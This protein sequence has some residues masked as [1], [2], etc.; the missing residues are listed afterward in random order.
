MERGWRKDRK[1]QFCSEPKDALTLQKVVI[2]LILRL[3]FF[4]LETICLQNLRMPAF[5][6]PETSSRCLA[7][8]LPAILATSLLA[9]DGSS[10]ANR[11][12]AKRQAALQEGQMLLEKGDEA[13]KAGK[14]EEA[15]AAYAGA[16]DSFPQA[17][18]TAELREAATQRYAQA[19]VEVSKLQA[20][21]GDVA[22]ARKTM[23]NILDDTVAPD[24]QLANTQLGYLD[25]PIRT[26]PSITKEHA[27]DVDT[28]RRL[29]Y[30][31]Q[32]AYDLGKYDEAKNNYEEV[33]RLDPYNQAARRG[34]ETVAS[35]KSAYYGS[36]LDH[37]KAELMA[38]V[39]GQWEL[40]LSA[41]IELP[42][43]TEA[44][45]LGQTAD[46]IP[47]SAK[48]SRIII[49]EFRIAQGNL[50]EAVELL[51][52]RAAENDTLTLDPAQ[53][54][55]NITLNLGDPL[56]SK[57]ILSKTFDLE[58]K[59]VP[60]DQV[61]NYIGQITG[62]RIKTGD[63]AVSFVAI[64][65]DAD[66]METRSYRVPPDFLS[67][68]TSGVTKED[69]EDTN[70][71]FNNQEDL[72]GLLVERMGPQ[73]ALAAS[74]RSLSRWR[75]SYFQCGNEYSPHRQ[76]PEKP[77]YHRANCPVRCSHRASPLH[78]AGHNDRSRTDRSGRARL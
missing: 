7:L 75:F 28:V 52:I 56:K 71:I 44:T 24:D 21:K 5:F 30:T 73:E 13:Y 6:F 59:N 68:I 12:L 48:L 17:A 49:P 34:L 38:Q 63:F 20:R 61:L 41:D 65:S 16:R 57:Q 55:V 40:P 76:Q 77:R 50:S 58:L 62:T 19:S 3:P 36:A 43:L 9:Q 32:G 29:L 15:A 11:E 35:T 47:V 78:R 2:S 26:N 70:D 74:R 39:D 66:V 8:A 45:R 4:L 37:T 33:L 23:E 42:P 27:A 53:K 22:G 1:N 10:L 64:G 25:D 54:G 14:Y 69:S 60:L 46:F 67:N 72:G 31:A 51:R 18:A